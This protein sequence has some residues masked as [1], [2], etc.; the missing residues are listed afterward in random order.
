MTMTA[1]PPISTSFG[2]YQEEAVLFNRIMPCKP[3]C[4]M[5]GWL[6]AATQ[7]HLAP[8]C[9]TLPTSAQSGWLTC[10][11]PWQ[12][13][14]HLGDTM[15]VPPQRLTKLHGKD[16]CRSS[17]LAYLSNGFRSAALPIAALT[18]AALPTGRWLTWC[19]GQERPLQCF[20]EI[21]PIFDSTGGSTET[22]VCE[23]LHQRLPEACQPAICVDITSAI[24][25]LSC[26]MLFRGCKQQP[27]LGKS[28]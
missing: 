4:A 14:S 6:R 10:R 25:R 3:F 23:L 26:I 17:F 8:M 16:L 15:A 21:S 5:F 22:M 27:R 9:N 7:Y 2:R 24:W 28:F 20:V 13:L 18:A 19:R 12:Q 11:I 1:G